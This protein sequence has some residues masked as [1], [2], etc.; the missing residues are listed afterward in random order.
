MLYA[1]TFAAHRGKSC[2]S[3]FLR[4]LLITYLITI[5]LEK[6]IYYCFG[7]S[8]EK[9]LNLRLKNLYEPYVLL[10]Y[11]FVFIYLFTIAVQVRNMVGK[12][13]ILF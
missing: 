7:K 13:H 10:F 9:A 3:V 6:E 11:W 2:P 4:I 12:L 5:S 8:P 1:C